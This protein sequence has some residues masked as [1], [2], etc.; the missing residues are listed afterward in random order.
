MSSFPVLISDGGR[1]GKL[2]A[3][4]HKIAIEVAVDGSGGFDGNGFSELF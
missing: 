3:D 4:G 1:V 2:W